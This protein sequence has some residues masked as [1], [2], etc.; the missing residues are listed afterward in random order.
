[1]FWANI[2]VPVANQSLHA[3]MA[4]ALLNTKVSSRRTDLFIILIVPKQHVKG[5]CDKESSQCNV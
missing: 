2:H 3:G 5:D 1:M 4:I